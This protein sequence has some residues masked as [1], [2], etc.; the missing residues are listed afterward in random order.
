[1]RTSKA[2]VMAKL[3]AHRCTICD[4]TAFMVA[5]ARHYKFMA[6]IISV[7]AKGSA[8]VGQTAIAIEFYPVVH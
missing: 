3:V 2:D 4:S 8:S 6:K 5:P 1:M 7:S